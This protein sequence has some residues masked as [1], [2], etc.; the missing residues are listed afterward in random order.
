QELL[1]SESTPVV[2]AFTDGRLASPTEAQILA[3]AERLAAAAR[4]YL[5]A[6]DDATRATEFADLPC[7]EIVAFDQLTLGHIDEFDWDALVAPLGRSDCSSP[8][9]YTRALVVYMER[10]HASAAQGNLANAEKAACDSVWRDLRQV[11][12]YAVDFGGLTP[13]SHQSLVTH[14][15]RFH[16]AWADGGCLEANRKIL[17]LIR[18]GVVDC[19]AGPSAAVS[20][21]EQEQRFRIRGPRT[22]FDK[23]VDVLIDARIP[24][25]DVERDVSPLTQALLQRGLIA[26]WVNRAADGSQFAAGGLHVSKRFEAISRDGRVQ[27]DLTFLGP[28]TE[29]LLFYQLGLARPQQNSHILNDVIAWTTHFQHRLEA[30][31]VLGPS[32]E[33]ISG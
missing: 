26:P 21:D 22:G 10:D 13:S 12:A 7:A 20:V 2:E 3:P 32:K 24:P 8:E 9:C 19:S 23:H 6:P 16:N 29:G 28:M 18:H 17:A 11:L 31:G 4:D 27:P 15:M 14:W 33:E 5:A 1:V 25:V 30:R